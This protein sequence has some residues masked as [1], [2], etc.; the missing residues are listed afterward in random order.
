[1]VIRDLLGK[2]IPV[3]PKVRLKVDIRTNKPLNVEFHYASHVASQYKTDYRLVFEHWPGLNA[4]EQKRGLH[5]A[6]SRLKMA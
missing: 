3:K 4:Q 6:V 2:K 1:M 5:R